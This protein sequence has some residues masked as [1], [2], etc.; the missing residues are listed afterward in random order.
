MLGEQLRQARAHA[1]LSIYALASQSGIG[2][3]TIS[4]I[5]SGKNKN[6]GLLTVARLADVLQVSLDTLAER[7]P[8]AAK[9]QRRRQ[10]AS[11]DSLG[12]A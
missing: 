9:R 7:T 11:V 2:I 1:G 12:G 3:A 5:E 10:A 6:P 4:E 8:V